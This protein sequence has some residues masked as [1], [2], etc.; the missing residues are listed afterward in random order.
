MLAAVLLSRRH[1][2]CAR[3][4]N[5]MLSGLVIWVILGGCADI[6]ITV[7]DKLACGHR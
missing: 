7:H 5:F 4:E 2:A 3:T 1:C 6:F